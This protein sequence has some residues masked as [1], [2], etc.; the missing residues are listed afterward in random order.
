MDILQQ[1]KGED[2]MERIRSRVALYLATAAV[3]LAIAAI[4]LPIAQPGPQGLMG[5]EGPVGAPGHAGDPGLM[6]PPGHAGD[7][8]LVGPPGPAGDP[9]SAM[10]F[11]M[12]RE[13]FSLQPQ[14]YDAGWY[15]DKKIHVDQGDLVEGYVSSPAVVAGRCDLAISGPE[16]PIR[17]YSRFDINPG[18]DFSFVADTSGEYVLSLSSASNHPQQGILVYWIIKK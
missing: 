1:T 2:R 16:S 14:G 7:P 17:R 4:F 13:E 3:L 10:H 5:P 18:I 6:G 9:G 15:L 11:S 8:G 12:E